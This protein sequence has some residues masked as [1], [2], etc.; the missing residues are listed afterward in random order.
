MDV[1]K[2]VNIAQ[3]Y[4]TNSDYRFSV[5][6]SLGFYKSMPDEEFLK[7]MFKARVGYP[8]DLD[9]PRTY[10]EKLQWLKL[11][12]RKPEF[13]QMV[14]KYEMKHFAANRIGEQYVIPNLGIWD[15][16]EDID[17]DHL[18]DQFV[19]KCTHDSG[20]L[21]ICKD[22]R[23][24]DIGA[25]RKK[26][27]KC[28]KS[29]YYLVGREWPYKN[30]KPR[31][32]AEVYMED[33]SE[34][35]L[36]DY[37]VLCFNGVAKLIQ[38]HRGRFVQHTQDFYDTDWNRVN[39]TQGPPQTAT[40]LEKPAFLEEMLSLSAELSKDIPHL[41]VDWYYVRGH[42]YLGELTFFDGSGF[43]P[44]EPKSF[45]RLLGDWIALPTER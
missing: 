18:P 30:V 21:V 29:N 22:K 33:S 13:T 3:R 10:N 26:I 43:E 11:H 23:T 5:N 24:L 35:A 14:D 39:I 41:R 16:V 34:S 2:M 15:R 6:A 28:L 25:A 7:R 31:I 45:D 44:F 17:F 20:G 40:D 8:L 27:N 1:K 12:Y 9:N 32:I 36:T 19:L 42:L 38:I 37:K 4:L